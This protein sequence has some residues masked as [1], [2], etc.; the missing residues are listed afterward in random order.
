[1]ACSKFLQNF[2][3]E[4]LQKFL[5]SFD[6][7]N[8]NSLFIGI[9]RILPWSRDSIEE[10]KN[11]SDFSPLGNDDFIPPVNDTDREKAN[12][13]RNLFFIKQVLSRDISFL[14]SKYSWEQGVVYDKYRDDAELFDPKK[15]FFVYN[16]TDKGVYKCLDN[17][18]DSPSES[19]PSSSNLGPF[20][21]SD[22]Y[23][24]KLMYRISD[25]AEAKFNIKSFSDLDEFIPVK[26]IDYFP[27]Q[28][29]NEEELEQKIIQDNSVNGSIE[30]VE[31]N[32]EFKNFISLD[33][34]KCAIGKNTCV[35]FEDA[36]TGATSVRVS[37]CIEHPPNQPFYLE[38]LVFNVVGDSS[39]ILRRIIKT[40]NLVIQTVNENE[41]ARYINLTFDTPLDR[42]LEQNTE[43]NIEPWIRVIG[44]GIAKNSESNSLGLNAAEFKPFFSLDGKLDNIKIVDSGK[45]YSY[46]KAIF[47]SGITNTSNLSEG[48]ITSWNLNYNSFLNPILPPSGGH[49][50]N[51]LKELGS[52]DLG[53]FTVIRGN[54][55]NKLTPINDFRQIVLIKNPILNNP[56]AH[57]RF[58][59]ELS[60]LLEE[61]T[62][63]SDI[64][65][66]QNTGTVK[67][68]YEY[69][70]G[71]GETEGFEIL[72]EGIS[73]SFFES[74]GIS[75]AN[76]SAT[77]DKS[78]IFSDHYRLYNIAGTENKSL[79][80]LTVSNNQQLFEGTPRDIV[81][82]IGQTSG[83]YVKPSL[84]SGMI[85]K[86]DLVGNKLTISL[87][88]YSG[89][90]NLGEKL[91]VIPRD[92]NEV[93]SIQDCN[94]IEFRYEKEESRDIG[95]SMTTKIEISTS[96]GLEMNANS[97]SLDQTIYSYK[98]ETSTAKY[99][100]EEIVGSGHLFNFVLESG[101]TATLEVVGARYE[102]FKV[103][104]FIPYNTPL[105]G[106]IEFA[107]INKVIEPEVRYDSGE[108]LY[109]NNLSPIVRTSANRDQINLVLST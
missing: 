18:N 86:L 40:S 36:M 84:A 74:E 92:G 59:T 108:V 35:I 7:D 28:V 11:P 5:D 107:I 79:L 12:A 49:G 87:E 98:E 34:E 95:Y 52:S 94:V 68:I 20:S 89:N 48:E 78:S 8:Q 67:R 109:M 63:V 17:N 25:T 29:G 47:E 9:G 22:N 38:N 3:N 30:F 73:G 16:E 61:G 90:F 64:S 65:N 53:L 75:F 54:E 14:V 19:V 106:D 26:F 21:T 80:K 57:L 32:P 102:S 66:P 82:G 27:P 2:R 33:R 44:D 96:E 23:T 10:I 42:M 72:L 93:A 99:L 69:E 31:I 56:V 104:D 103:G 24:W 50:S 6:N 15:R 37:A 91:L 1:M 62:E 46:A 76:T 105:G 60:S 58:S 88:D 41:C 85:R 71:D 55:E 101:T 39:D 13:K 100:S 51:S 97:F 4:L 43:F 81:M 77:I 83:I 70:Y 45:N